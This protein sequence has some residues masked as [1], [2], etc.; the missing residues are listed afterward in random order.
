MAMSPANA[1]GHRNRRVI[2]L[3]V[4]GGLWLLSAPVAQWLFDLSVEGA[5]AYR[6]FAVVI[7]AAAI[8]LE[9]RDR[10][11]TSRADFKGEFPS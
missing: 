6:L 5:L 8:V 11:R 10:R 1:R 2:A 7:F 3:L 4:V 9:L